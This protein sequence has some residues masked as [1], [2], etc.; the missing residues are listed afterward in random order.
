M[1][2]GTKPT[3]AAGFALALGWS[4]RSGAPPLSSRDRPRIA[5]RVP[6]MFLQTILSA[7]TPLSAAS[8]QPRRQPSALA[9]AAPKAMST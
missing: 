3:L 2:M 8:P 1:V 6:P 5:S 9:A 4:W 7:A